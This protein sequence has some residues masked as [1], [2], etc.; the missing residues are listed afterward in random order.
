MPTL[1]NLRLTSVP[2]WFKVNNVRLPVL[3]AN[4]PLSL[5]AQTVG[6]TV[7]YSEYCSNK[8]QKMRRISAPNFSQP[9]TYRTIS[10]YFT[11]TANEMCYLGIEL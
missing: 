9:F 2:G 3:L 1:A 4:E 11:N 8:L 7:L 5:K 6:K 10:Q